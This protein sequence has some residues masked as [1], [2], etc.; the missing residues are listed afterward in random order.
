M[1]GRFDGFVGKDSSCK[2]KQGIGPNTDNTP[3]KE[4][5][6]FPVIAQEVSKY[7]VIQGVLQNMQ[8]SYSLT[9]PRVRGFNTNL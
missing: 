1:L 9:R 7:I 6:Q 2:E 8:H 5:G 3:G 4:Q